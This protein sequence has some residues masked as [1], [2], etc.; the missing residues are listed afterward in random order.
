MG[1][2]HVA[3]P[4]T[5]AVNYLITIIGWCPTSTENQARTSATEVRG[6][7]RA[8]KFAVPKSLRSSGWWPSDFRFQVADF[9]LSE[10]GEAAWSQDSGN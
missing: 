8:I 6:L 4:A 10:Q 9:R 3:L 1:S 2:A 5:G 7:Y